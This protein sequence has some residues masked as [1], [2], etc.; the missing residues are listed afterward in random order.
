MIGKVTKLVGCPTCGAEAGR[1]CRPLNPDSDFNVP[2]HA[3]RKLLYRKLPQFERQNVI[4]D[5]YR[6]MTPQR[7]NGH[8]G[9]H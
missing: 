1:S 3:A 8:N 5:F 7:R 6:N 2:N 9:T 4:Y